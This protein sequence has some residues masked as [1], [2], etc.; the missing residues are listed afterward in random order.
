MTVFTRIFCRELPFEFHLLLVSD[1]IPSFKR[2]HVRN[3]NS[4]CCRII[5]R[6]P[7]TN[8]RPERE[9]TRTCERRRT[10]VNQG[11]QRIS[12]GKILHL[13]HLALQLFVQ[14]QPR[15]PVCTQ[16]LLVS[17]RKTARLRRKFTRV[18]S[19]TRVARATIQRA[20]A[21]LDKGQTVVGHV[22]IV[23]VL[24]EGGMEK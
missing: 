7:L 20:K 5:E 18:L 10:F 17:W 12:L 16:S 23:P 8:G 21:T 13:P 14:L 24:V 22:P 9:P 2:N 4:L 6:D 11:R 3:T 1:V 19:R 15:P